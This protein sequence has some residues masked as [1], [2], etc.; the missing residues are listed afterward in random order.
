MNRPRFCLKGIEQ[1]ITLQARILAEC[2]HG[3]VTASAIALAL[4]ALSDR[5]AISR[6]AHEL[7]RAGLLVRRKVERGRE[8]VWDL[9]G[10][11]RDALADVVEQARAFIDGGRPPVRCWRCGDAGTLDGCGRCGAPPVDGEGSRTEFRG[12]VDRPPSGLHESDAHNGL[13]QW[14]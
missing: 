1:P 13:W 3:E 9:T 14:D 6:G 8:P 11:G 2:D 7:A 4:D 5:A 10:Q 12:A